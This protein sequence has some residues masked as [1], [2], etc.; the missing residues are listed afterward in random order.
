MQ[1]YLNSSLLNNN[2]NELPRYG[3]LLLDWIEQE[4]LVARILI[5]EVFRPILSLDYNPLCKLSHLK[6]FDLIFKS[7]CFAFQ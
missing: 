1:G 6:I 2:Y 3:K 4:K 7:N 5:E